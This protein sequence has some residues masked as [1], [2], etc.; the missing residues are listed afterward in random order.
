MVFRCDY[1]S[2]Y[3]VVSVRRS[4]RRSVPCYFRRWKELILG[5]SCAVYPALF[6][7]CNLVQRPGLRFAVLLI[8]TENLELHYLCI[9]S[10][11]S[12]WRVCFFE[13]LLYARN[14]CACI[15]SLFLVPFLR[16]L[17]S[18]LRLFPVKSKRL[19][20]PGSQKQKEKKRKR[21]QERKKR[22]ERMYFQVLTLTE[23][24]S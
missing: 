9:I 22:R 11:F 19:R 20:G 18:R 16:G 10:G 4:A 1:A 8:L 17:L 6:R 7:E 2:L 24:L 21:K 13:V 15:V 23:S 3:E 12:H 14:T 5:A